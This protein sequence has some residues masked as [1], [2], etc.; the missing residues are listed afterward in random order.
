MRKLSMFFLILAIGL[1]FVSCATLPI[2]GDGNGD[3]P[4][5]QVVINTFIGTVRESVE[6]LA[7]QDGKDGTWKKLSSTNGVYTFTPESPDGNFSI[8][9]VDERYEEWNGEININYDIQIMNL[10]TSEGKEVPITFGDW[11]DTWDATLNLNFGNEFIDKHASIF[12]GLGHGFPGFDSE[13]NLTFPLEAIPGT[14]DLVLLV[15]DQSED[16]SKIYIDRDRS[17]SAGNDEQEILWSD[18]ISLETYTATTTIENAY[19]WGELLV[20]GTTDV[21][22]WFTD[23][24]Q[25]KIPASLKSPN[26][27]YALGVTKYGNQENPASRSFTK[28][29]T[30]PNDIETLNTLPSVNWEE[31]TFSEN[32]FSWDKYD[33]E[34][35]GHELRY[36]DT[37]LENTDWTI[38]WWIILSSGWLGSSDSYEYQIPNLSDLDD[39]NDSWYPNTEEVDSYDNFAAI[40]GTE[41][42]LTKYLDP[43]AGMEVSTIS[44]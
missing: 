10:N 29:K 41:D 13:D 15:G 43:I 3:I 1:L 14:Y 44:Y 2:G 8:Y 31:P 30:Y 27:L 42:D 16:L 37:Y 11:P 38:S 35:T 19:A 33:P 39:W 34:I 21:F 24:S 18:F 17:I 40:S 6:F 32:T 9:A 12:Y 36:Y 23:N 26:D 5:D 7:Y 4:D 25:L 28:L 20:G 22:P